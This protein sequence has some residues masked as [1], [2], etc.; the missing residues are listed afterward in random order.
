MSAGRLPK[1]PI[2]QFFTGFARV[3][4]SWNQQFILPGA[5]VQAD[6]FCDAGKFG[7]G[8]VVIYR[9]TNSLR[10]NANFSKIANPVRASAYQR[11]IQ[12]LKCP[13]NRLLVD[14]SEPHLAL[15]PTQCSQV[16]RA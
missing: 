1:L 15:Q 5:S 2:D 6:D 8:T 11:P 16:R 14:H 12:K 3:D 7:G 4:S 9:H 10:H 13:S